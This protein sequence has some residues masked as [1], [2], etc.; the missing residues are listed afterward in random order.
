MRNY[1]FRAYDIVD[2]RMHYLDDKEVIFV[3]NNVGISLYLDDG[4]EIVYF[5]LMQYT[6]NKDMNGKEIYE[7][8]IVNCYDKEEELHFNGIVAFNDCGFVIKEGCVTHYRWIDYY[9]TVIGNIYDNPELLKVVN[10]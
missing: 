7:G 3:I 4:T 6:D 8:D 5:E 9:I 2:N 1:K 10:K